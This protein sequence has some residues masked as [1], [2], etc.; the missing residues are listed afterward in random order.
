MRFKNHTLSPIKGGFVR[1]IYVWSKGVELLRYLRPHVRCGGLGNLRYRNSRNKRLGADKRIELDNRSQQHSGLGIREPLDTR[2]VSLN[3]RLQNTPKELSK[4]GLSLEGACRIHQRETDAASQSAQPVFQDG[5]FVP[6]GDISG[7]AGD[8]ISQMRRKYCV[9]LTRA[10]YEF[11]RFMKYERRSPS[12][13]HG[14]NNQMGNLG[15][16]SGKWQWRQVILT[17]RLI[18]EQK[19]YPVKTK[20]LNARSQGLGESKCQ[21]SNRLNMKHQN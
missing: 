14:R 7:A 9:F 21:I 15:S 2:L 17:N 6:H 19:L 3:G 5:E 4:S 10:P 12:A 13:T 20:Y 16:T 1:N 18:G 11:R 8:P